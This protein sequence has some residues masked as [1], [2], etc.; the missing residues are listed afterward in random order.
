MATL[1]QCDKKH[2]RRKDIERKREKEREERKGEGEG[3]RERERERDSKRGREKKASQV[4][5]LLTEILSLSLY[6]SQQYSGEKLAGLLGPLQGS[7]HHTRPTDRVAN[8]IAD[9]EPT[10]TATTRH[11]NHVFR[12]NLFLAATSKIAL[13]HCNS[14]MHWCT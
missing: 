13:N 5:S 2:T 3:E 14:K 4:W 7:A 8:L 10:A 12:N 9:Q 1:G 6:I 11:P